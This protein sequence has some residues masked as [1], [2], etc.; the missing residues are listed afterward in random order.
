MRS[1]LLVSLALVLA[2]CGDNV[3]DTCSSADDCSGD[4]YCCTEG[5]CGGGI[6]T[7][8][9][10]SDRDCDSDMVCRDDMCLFTCETDRDCDPGFRCDEKDGR[11]MCVGD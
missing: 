7:Y 2:A 11:L 6:C 5:K 1:I 9:C 3:G 4:T 10:S 8:R